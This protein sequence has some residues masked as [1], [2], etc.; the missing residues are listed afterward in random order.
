ML[1]SQVVKF[2]KTSWDH[3]HELFGDFGW[4]AIQSAPFERERLLS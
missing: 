3:P 4:D 2:E 1:L